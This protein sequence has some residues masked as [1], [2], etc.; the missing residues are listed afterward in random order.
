MFCSLRIIL[1][2]FPRKL[3]TSVDAC[4]FLLCCEEAEWMSLGKIFSG[5]LVLWALL[6]GTFD[7]A[8]GTQTKEQSFSVY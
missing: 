4:K 3:Q 2:N 5:L 8:L 1:R 6:L 7:R